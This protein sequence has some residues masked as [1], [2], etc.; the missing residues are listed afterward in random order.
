MCYPDR[1][2]YITLF[3]QL[4]EEF[5]AAP[6]LN[7]TESRSRFGGYALYGMFSV[8]GNSNSRLLLGFCYF[9]RSCRAIRN[10]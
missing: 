1:D 10:S 9:V 6:P 4:L 2:Y 7:R 3:F 8:G 5:E